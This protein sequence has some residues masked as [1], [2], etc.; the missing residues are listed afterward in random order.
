MMLAEMMT[1][2]HL[3][4]LKNQ[5][6]AVPHVF[7]E[8][9][10]LYWSSLNVTGPETKSTNFIDRF[11][12]NAPK[13]QVKEI[14]HNVSGMAE[15][16]KLLAIM[17]SS[18]AGKTTL[19]NVLTS[20][21]LTNL[22][23]QGSI[24]IDGK[25]ANKWKIR[26]MSAFVQQHDMFVGTMTA[27]EHLQFMARLRMGSEYY[28]EE[29]RET[30]VNQVLTQMGLQKCADTVIGIPN[31][32]K[33]LSCGEKKRLAF[34][35]EILTCPKILFCDEPTSGLD[36]FMAGHVVQALRRLA[37]NGMTVII[38]IH[39]PSSQVYSLF[40][41]VCLMACGRVIYLGPG[42]QA[43]PLFERCGFP[44]PAYYN[45]ADHLIRTLAVIDSDRATS[46][47]TISKIRQGFL[48]TDLGQSVL[49]IGNANK[50]RA[51]SFATSSETSEKTKTFFNQD[52]NA[53][54][55]T[56]FRA[57]FW[58]SYLTVIR[59]P[60]LLSVRLLQIIIT[61]LITGLVFFQTPV[62]PA[63]IIS[64]N[65]I[66]FNHIR[67]MN[68]MLQFPNVPVITAELPIVLRE[69]ANG[70]YRTSAYFLAKNIAELPQ[71]IILPVLYNTIVYWLSGLYPNFW[72][73]CF[74]SLVTI[75]I[76]NVAI[77]I[78]YAVATIF[79]NTDVAMTVLPIFVVP[80]MAFG[81]FFITFDAI[82]S[83]FTWLSSLSYFKY[84]YEALA[85]NEW[86][87]IKV[88]P[89]C[90]NS[91]VTAFALNGCPRNG[92]E[93]LESIDFSA[94]HKI[95]DIAILFVMFI[96]IRIIAY[97]A[98]LIRSYNNT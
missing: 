49:A 76:T 93:V 35:S 80:I 51:A 54:F 41:N 70:V 77:S 25:R 95:F 66:M 72:N 75:L 61:A 71:Y 90:F 87:S 26:E 48:S 79:A 28:S 46:M 58:R 63:T 32:L 57:L 86:E 69:N 9:C 74:A 1:G 59:D 33:G 36:A 84:G 5:E 21:N 19:M 10:N 29:E 53:S 17:G 18:G 64:V 91:S 94:S 12:N 7:P 78:S 88:I 55:W 24:L 47:K 27:R 98:L 92:Y 89:E 22:D 85:I 42:D 62:T 56:Q 40:N 23:V 13:R 97:V 68:F 60:N 96:G 82:P 4:L 81:G 20:R 73:Y 16:G 8:G 44:C 3:Q 34:A 30:R 83:Y 11:R 6:P 50:L 39:Q 14:L 31:Q 43:V 15:S 2:D 52:Y 45:P 65:G 67:N 37:D 38:T